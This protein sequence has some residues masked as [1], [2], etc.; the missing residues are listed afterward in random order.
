M[1]LPTWSLLH[2][3]CWKVQI[4]F[5][6]RHYRVITFGPRGNGRSSRPAEQETYDERYFAADAVAVLDATD[7]ERA[8]VVGFSTGAQRGLLLAAEHP[9]R[10]MGVVFIAPAVPLGAV[11]ARA[12]HHMDYPSSDPDFIA[13][14]IAELVGKPVDY[15]DVESDG[16]ARAAQLIA[17]LV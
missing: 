16:A 2:S 4:P 10:V 8:V 12:G 1:L 14:R 13:A 9:E 5:L 6:A 7:T 15:R 17:E 11:P 3:R